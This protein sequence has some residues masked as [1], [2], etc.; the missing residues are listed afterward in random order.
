MTST[1]TAASQGTLGL[2]FGEYTINNSLQDVI[3]SVV[4]A[5]VEQDSSDKGSWTRV[6]VKRIALDTTYTEHQVTREIQR[7]L[8]ADLLYENCYEILDGVF[9]IVYVRNANELNGGD[10]EYGEHI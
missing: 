9:P 2:S 8:K 1:A 4:D 5:I 10:N 7:M 6:V 3:L